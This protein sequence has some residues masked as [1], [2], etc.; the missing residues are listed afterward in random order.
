[1]SWA[2][3]VNGKFNLG[4]NGKRISTGTFT[5]AATA[6]SAVVTGLAKVEYCSATC[7]SS[8]AAIGCVESG[9]AGTITV[10]ATNDGTDDGFWIAIGR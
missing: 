6:G 4:H 1:M 7:S 2:Y 5:D 8:A 10:T 3:T 9:T